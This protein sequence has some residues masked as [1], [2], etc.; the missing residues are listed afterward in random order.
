MRVA[1]SNI[2]EKNLFS[3]ADTATIKYH[4]CVVRLR[5]KKV[6]KTERRTSPHSQSQL[7]AIS[8][9]LSIPF[10]QSTPAL[11]FISRQPAAKPAFG[12]AVRRYGFFL[13][14][15]EQTNRL[16]GEWNFYAREE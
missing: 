3:V 8:S 14:R 9:F 2:M 4:Q 16:P 13:G 15:E 12:G 1:E 6:N 10:I 11:T 7:V 5:V